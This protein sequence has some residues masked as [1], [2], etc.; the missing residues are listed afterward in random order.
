MLKFKRK[1]KGASSVRVAPSILSCDFAHIAA[2]IKAVE[3]AGADLIHVDVMDGHFVDNL[4]IGPPVIQSIRGATKLPFDVHLMIE[5]PEDSF[6]RFIKAGANI[7]TIHVEATAKPA[8]IL[9]RIR[10][11]GVKP[12]ITLRPQTDLSAVEPFLSLV[13]L[14]LVMTVN[15]G[16]GG[17]SFMHDQLKKVE[18]LA[19]WARTYNPALMIEVDGGINKE[20]AE[21]CRVAGA[22]TFVAG[23]FVFKNKSYKKAISEIRG[24]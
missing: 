24:S 11:A 16:W 8:E 10:A 22:N 21:L 17:Q 20:T 5:K 23:S 12:G 4:T 13:D 19:T 18:R 2:E 7:L 9:Q 6:E 15:P 1:S 14:V 3:K